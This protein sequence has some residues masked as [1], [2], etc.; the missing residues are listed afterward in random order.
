MAKIRKIKKKPN[1]ELIP[2]GTVHPG[3]VSATITFSHSPDID[4]KHTNHMVIQSDGEDVF[5]SFFD[6]PPPMLLTP[7]QVAE[8]TRSMSVEGKC[9]SRIAM[10]KARLPAFVKACETALFQLKEAAELNPPTE[11]H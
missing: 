2:G 7:E 3:A 5:I 4:T 8:F 6:I 10:S 11:S 1:T 9:V